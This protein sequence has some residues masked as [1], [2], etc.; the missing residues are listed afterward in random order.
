M[1]PGQALIL[2]LIDLS[3]FGMNG[4]TIAGASSFGVQAQLG[5]RLVQFR[6]MDG[7]GQA[8]ASPCRAGRARGGNGR[9]PSRR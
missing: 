9:T 2:V 7:P 3:A 6:R 5:Q 1:Q 8:A 4:S